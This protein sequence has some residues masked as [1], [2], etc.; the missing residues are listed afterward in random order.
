MYL[1]EYL[2]RIVG[3]LKGKYTQV[4]AHW[5]WCRFRVMSG[6]PDDECLSEACI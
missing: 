1:K 6:R 4:S 5:V 3:D 2:K